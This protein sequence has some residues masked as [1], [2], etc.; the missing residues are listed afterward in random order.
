M[1]FGISSPYIEAF[2]IARAAASKVFTVI[3]TVPTINLSKGKGDKLKDLQGR[4]TFTNV[5]FCYPSRKDVPVNYVCFF[6]VNH[7]VRCTKIG[8]NVSIFRS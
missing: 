7:A 4:I 2:G 6:N 1:N 8:Y 3:D 5:D